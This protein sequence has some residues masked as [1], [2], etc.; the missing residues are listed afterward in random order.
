M[1]H[2]VTRMAKR[3]LV[4]RQECPEDGRGA[5]VVITPQGMGTIKAAAPRHV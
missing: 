2:Q 4:T 1:S 5:F 3:G